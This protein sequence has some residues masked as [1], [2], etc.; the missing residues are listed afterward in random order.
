MQ[1]TWIFKSPFSENLFDSIGH[2]WE[3][4]WFKL[5]QKNSCSSLLK[6]NIVLKCL[7]NT[8]V[9]QCSM[10]NL[11]YVVSDQSKHLLLTYNRNSDVLCVCCDSVTSF[12]LYGKAAVYSF[13]LWEN[14]IDTQTP[15]G[16]LRKSSLF[17]WFF[18]L[19]LPLNLWGWSTFSATSYNP[20][21]ISN[22]ILLRFPISKSCCWKKHNIG[23]QVIIILY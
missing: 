3:N 4:K 2:E 10:A 6:Y 17:Q 21:G 7:L 14:S 12:T 19:S 20:R 11:K 18:I 8:A 23:L 9:H 15:T 22:N 13:I 16:K 5:W 1:I